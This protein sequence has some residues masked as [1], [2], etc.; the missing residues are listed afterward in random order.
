MPDLEWD[1]SIFQVGGATVEIIREKLY[2]DDYDD[3]NDF[4]DRFN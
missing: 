3:Y 1:R 4:F 2:N